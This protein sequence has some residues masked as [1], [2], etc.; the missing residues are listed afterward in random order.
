MGP[1]RTE[2]H[3]HMAGPTHH[4]DLP[5][6]T[7]LPSVT[8]STSPAAGPGPAAY[9]RPSC[10]RL[11]FSPAHPPLSLPDAHCFQHQVEEA[12]SAAKLQRDNALAAS[13]QQLSS[14][15][16]EAAA[17]QQTAAK[18]RVELNEERHARQVAES[19][20]AQLKWVVLV[21]RGMVAQ[22][23]YSRLG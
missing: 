1:N 19:N 12:A 4:S 8:S 18:T 6:H 5:P 20:L 23:R 22:R 2:L 10:G 21:G 11:P 9:I 13:A 14:V 16:A 15:R 7:F 17:A 3:P